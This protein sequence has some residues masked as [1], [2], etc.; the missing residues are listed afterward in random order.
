MGR[1]RAVRSCG[2]C[3]NENPGKSSSIERLESAPPKGPGFLYDVYQSGV[4][5]P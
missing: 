5:R 2:P 4:S 3:Q 1:S